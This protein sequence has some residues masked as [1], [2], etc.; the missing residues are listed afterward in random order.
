MDIRDLGKTGPVAPSGPRPNQA[1]P[2]RN[3]VIPSVGRDEARI[4]ASSRETAAAVTGLAERAAQSGSDRRALV[5]AARQ[6]LVSGQ[7]DTPAA[8]TAAAAKLADSG[9]ASV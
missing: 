1:A 9:F 7:L 5:E 6:K 8:F 3:Y 4:S 2:P